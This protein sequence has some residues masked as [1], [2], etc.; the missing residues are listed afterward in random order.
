MNTVLV[1]LSVAIFGV[2]IS[3][4]T[5]YGRDQIRQEIID[6]CIKRNPEMA[7]SKIQEYCVAQYDALF[8]I[9]EK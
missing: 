1:L 4:T 6:S 7:N 9:K 2:I 3:A 5:A 8:V